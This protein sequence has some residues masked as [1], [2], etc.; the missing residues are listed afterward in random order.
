MNKQ[1]P[2]TASQKP[3]FSKK[4]RQDNNPPKMADLPLDPVAL[5]FPHHSHC[6]GCELEFQA[7]QTRVE[8]F[9]TSTC[10]RDTHRAFPVCRCLSAGS[11]LLVLF[12]EHAGRLVCGLHMV[13]PVPHAYLPKPLESLFHIV[14]GKFSSKCAHVNEFSLV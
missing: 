12:L 4:K 14:P 10:K 8:G 7:L 13:N 2:G 6:G 9:F 5:C 11:C 3:L 1:V